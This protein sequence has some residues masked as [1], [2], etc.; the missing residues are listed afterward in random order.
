MI[1]GGFWFNLRSIAAFAIALLGVF[2]MLYWFLLP[3][4]IYFWRLNLWPL[5][6]TPLGA[7]LIAAIVHPRSTTTARQRVRSL[8][9]GYGILFVAYLLLFSSAFG[10]NN[11]HKYW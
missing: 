7:G 3:K 1:T 5:L 2:S 9:Y 8:A 6:A 10:A 4:D 11:T